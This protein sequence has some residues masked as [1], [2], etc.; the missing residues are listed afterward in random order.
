MADDLNLNDSIR[1]INNLVD[2]ARRQSHASSMRNDTTADWITNFMNRMNQNVESESTMNKET[3]QAHTVD[4]MVAQLRSRVGLDSLKKDATLVEIPL[5]AKAIQK[6]K[7]D[8]SLTDDD[9]QNASRFIDDFFS[10]HRGYA[11]VPAVL[12]ACRDK[13]GND[14]VAE[15]LDF[16][17]KTIDEAKERNH[18][19]GMSSILPSP[20]QGQPLKVDLQHDLFQPLFENIKNL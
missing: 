16:F 14:I 9:K 12:Y 3:G 19:P 7:T 11:D 8:S 20:Y 10:S 13:F 17:S 18:S 5:T 6:K 15:N 2:R 4:S 1:Q